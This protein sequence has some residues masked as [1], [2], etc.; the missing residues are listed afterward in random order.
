MDQGHLSGFWLV[1]VNSVAWPVIHI[2]IGYLS[3][4]IPDRVLDHSLWLFRTRLW[5]R[6]GAIYEEIFRVRKWKSLIPSGG[7]VFRG[8]FSLKRLVS[9][10]QEY[11]RK[12]VLESCRAEVTHWICL[13]TVLLFFLWNPLLGDIL[14]TIYVVVAN[15]PCIIVQRYNRPRLLVRLPAQDK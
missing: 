2:S 7:T 13:P 14:N 9:H 3:Q 5:E 1:L 8:G 6:H 4:R 11:L 12:W 10:D 15:V